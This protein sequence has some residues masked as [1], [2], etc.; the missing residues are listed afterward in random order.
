[1]KPLQLTISGWG[2]YKGK[3]DIDFTRFENRGLFLIT[4]AT[5]AG[6]TTIFDALTY[7]L[8]GSLSGGFREKNSV[9]SDFAGEDTPTFIELVMSH[10]GKEYRIYRNPEYLRPKKRK[11]GKDTF[12][13]EKENA[14]LYLPEGRVIEGTR[15]VNAKI[16]ELLVLD[17]AQFKQ[18][19]MIAQGEFARL[20]TAPPRDKLN[21]FREIFGTGIYEKF[22]Q[23]LRSRA[24]A[25]EAAAARQK[26]KMEED[27]RLLL[28][29]E[30]LAEEYE[31]L[32][33]YAENDDWDYDIILE[34][35]ESIQA[36]LNCL[37]DRT[38]REYRQA[39]EMTQRLAGQVQQEQENNRKLKELERVG[40]KLSELKQLKDA[41]TEK[42]EALKKARNAAFV[43]TAETKLRTARSLYEN[44]LGRLKTLDTDIQALETEKESL[45]PIYQNRETL[46]A[47]LEN[48]SRMEELREEVQCLLESREV[49][50]GEYDSARER[51][52]EAEQERDGLR[53]AY[54]QADRAYKRAAA[55]IAAGMLKEG[56]PCPVCG[57]LNHP[58]PARVQEDILSEKELLALKQKSG[59]AEQFLLKQHGKA[60]AL[61]AEEESL[62]KQWE[63][64][65][66]QLEDCN[67]RQKDLRK[68]LTEG[69][70]SQTFRPEAAVLKNSPAEQNGREAGGAD[71]AVFPELPDRKTLQESLERYGQTEGSLASKRQQRQALEAELREQKDEVH[72]QE[73]AFI[74]VLEEHGFENEG[75]YRAAQRPAGERKSLEEETEAYKKELAG[76]ANLAKH[77]EEAAEGLMLTDEEETG[78]ELARCQE[79]KEKS[80]LYQEKLS[81]ASSET[82]K[83][84]R[85]LLEKQEKLRAAVTEYGYVKD[86]E[87]MASG[88]NGKKLVFEQYVL[89]GYFEEILKAANLRF[90]DMT[91]GRYEMSR[92]EEVGDGRSKD[93]LE[94][95]VMDY[96]TGKVRSVKT[97]S[98]G[99][100]FKASLSLALGLSDVIQAMNGGIRVDALFIDEGFGALDGESL[101]Q[102]CEAL[103]GLVEQE[104][105]TGIISHVPELRERI[106]NQLIVKKTNCGSTIEI[107]VS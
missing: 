59:E 37:Q 68:R 69:I 51:Y 55:G 40:L 102:A 75:K 56:S 73:R 41:M 100:A 88:Y 78:R 106:E 49:R 72:R 89:A 85:S 62:S 93:N 9:R 74:S 45:S 36:E 65:V 11:T 54:E 27:V 95:Q 35:M 67:T 76:T 15:E 84:R 6:K 46:Q 107:M 58:A 86:L 32:R 18:I 91:G 105:L 99:E 83:T 7:A 61:K 101:D 48:R 70:F 33:R 1:M 19:S 31:R 90:C 4:G 25:L 2:P 52:L 14:V 98:G 10:G 47:L 53:Q 26:H 34:Y 63:Q 92:M 23:T 28:E 43:E 50:K 13:R 16:Q 96:Y 64:C 97:L 39:E 60:V 103:R 42:E 87:N 80:R 77:L 66:K 20:L 82:E 94:I 5:G 22:T 57:S 3:A 24:A 21:I 104:R 30:D 8:Y 12:T 71:N 17:Y 79:N 29:G 38:L 81:R 44:S